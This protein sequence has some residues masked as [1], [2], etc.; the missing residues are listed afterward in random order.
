MSINGIDTLTNSSAYVQTNETT[1]KNDSAKKESTTNTADTGVI[2]ERGSAAKKTATYTQNTELV[3]KLKADAEQRTSQLKSLVEQMMT[4]QGTAIGKASG[5]DDIWKFLAGGDYTVDA[6]T[7]KQAQEDISEDG[8][9]GVKQ[10]SERI[11]SFAKALSGGDPSK[12]K[13]LRN[14]FEKGFK[15]ATSAWGKKLPDISQDTYDAVMDGF[16][17]WENESTTNQDTSA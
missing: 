4:K 8:Y 10:T 1:K 15:Q 5:N 6:A 11:V 13:L 17:D 9:W 16:D 3:N 2:Y 12:I 7:K 14:A